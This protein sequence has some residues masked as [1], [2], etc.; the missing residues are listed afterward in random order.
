VKLLSITVIFAG[1]AASLSAAAITGVVN[2]ASAVP[3]DLP[4]SGIAQ[5]SIFVVYGSGLGPA[6]LQEIQ[7]YP[8][9]R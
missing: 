1:C 7:S 9:P 8:L 4:N 3:P 2:S 6:A 5:G